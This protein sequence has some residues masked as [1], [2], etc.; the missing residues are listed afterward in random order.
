M[1]L[2]TPMGC[3]DPLPASSTHLSGQDG[4]TLHFLVAFDLFPSSVFPSIILRLLLLVSRFFQ[5]LHLPGV[6]ASLL[7]NQIFSFPKHHSFYFVPTYQGLHHQI[8]KDQTQLFCLPQYQPKHQP[9]CM[10][11]HSRDRTVWLCAKLRTRNFNYLT[12]EKLE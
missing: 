1:M 2:A 8:Q 12:T 10:T 7:Q 5:F 6:F 4:Q 9:V 11:C 3:L